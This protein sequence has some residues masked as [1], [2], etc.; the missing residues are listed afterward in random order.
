[1]LLQHFAIKKPRPWRPV[2]DLCRRAV[3]L[4]RRAV[5]AE[6]TWRGRPMMIKRRT[7]W[8]RAVAAISNIY[9][10]LAG[11]PISFCGDERAWQRWEVACFRVLNDDGFE[12]MATRHG[13]VRMSRLPG[14]ALWTHLK[15]GT[16]TMQMIDAA[17]REFRRAHALF[18]DELQGPW[19][20]G[21]ACTENVV[22]DEQTGRARLID[23]EFVHDRTLS[24]EERHADDVFVFLLDLL[25]VGPKPE[26]VP[27]AVRFLRT[28]D[29]PRVTRLALA[30]LVPTTGM[31]WCW[32]KV[33]THFAR[34][35]T[36][37]EQIRLLREAI[38]QA[39]LAGEDGTESRS[40]AAT[41]GL[42]AT[43]RLRRL[44][45]SRP[46]IHCQYTSAG[47]PTASSRTRRISAKAIAVS[48]PI[49]NSLPTTT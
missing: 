9:F 22:Y 25:T 19:S 39:G 21:D 32:W 16:L 11:L 18:S 42:R 41:P 44:Q 10:R 2:V 27:L 26:R 15:R 23:F 29:D 31:Q 13:A 46:S 20:H 12:A 8:G 49:P 34:P 1:M 33:R 40:N 47:T 43:D 24:A 38:A 14:E 6:T 45:K 5:T 35:T 36:L 17:A 28:Y 30:R 3:A 37:R 48:P 7:F 4:T